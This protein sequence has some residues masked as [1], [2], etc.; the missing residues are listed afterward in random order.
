MKNIFLLG[1]ALAVALRRDVHG[2]QVSTPAGHIDAVLAVVDG[3]R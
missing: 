2:I 3:L 1:V